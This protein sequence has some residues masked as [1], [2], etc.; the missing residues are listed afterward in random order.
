MNGR[1]A[2][3]KISE[4]TANKF[5]LAEVPNLDRQV[6]TDFDETPFWEAFDEVLDQLEL[7]VSGGDGE[8]IRL[9][10][11]A[12]HAPL[13]FAAAGYSGVFRIEPLVVQKINQMLRQPISKW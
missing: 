2:L 5:E 1:Q 10:P 3:T 6:Q 4:Q 9:V 11:R 13:R 12:V 7:T 8:S